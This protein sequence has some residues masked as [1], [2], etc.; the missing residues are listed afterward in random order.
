M[1]LSELSSF[2]FRPSSLALPHMPVMPQT[3]IWYDLNSSSK[4]LP[5]TLSGSP[6]ISTASNPSS[7]ICS[8][9]FS[10]G[11]MLQNDASVIAYLN[12]I[13]YLFLFSFSLVVGYEEAPRILPAISVHFIT[14]SLCSWMTPSDDDTYKEYPSP[15]A[16]F[17]GLPWEP[18]TRLVSRGIFLVLKSTNSSTGSYPGFLCMSTFL[19]KS[20][21]FSTSY[22]Q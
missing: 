2:L 5:L 18:L 16:E 22:H 17:A 12:P 10:T 14:L 21:A 9:V 20:G 11:S 7:D 15:V 8:S 3:E 13:D 19:A 1:S 4:T 6:Y